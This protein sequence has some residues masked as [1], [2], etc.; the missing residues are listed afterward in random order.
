MN[1]LRSFS[2]LALIAVLLFGVSCNEKK[3]AKP[4][5]NS[6]K[7]EQSASQPMSI[8]YVDEDSI[9][10]N[11]ILAKEIN[12][13]ML[14][15]QNQYDAASQQRGNELNK[16]ANSMQQKYKNN[17]YLTEES[18]NADQAK[19]QKMQTD[20]ENYLGGM[21]QRM[22]NE[23]AQS[24]AQLLDSIDNYMKIYAKEKGYDMVIRKSATL[25]VDERFDVTDEVI[26]GLNKRYNKVSNK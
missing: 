21:Q 25:Y 24:Q 18:F 6:A 14:R 7:T 5:K 19:L 13:A 20:A 3:P 22:Q 26:E 9:M 15:K 8:R 10:S 11:Y 1:L 16:F 12:E 23:L 4:A 2:A 17:G